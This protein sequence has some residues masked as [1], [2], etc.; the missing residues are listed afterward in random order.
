MP[1]NK[2]E[3]GTEEKGE[4]V[5]GRKERGL[6]GMPQSA[7]PAMST[8]SFSRALIRSMYV[9]FF[10]FPPA[11]PRR[12]LLL[13]ASSR[14]GWTGTTAEPGW[15]PSF[16]YCMPYVGAKTIYQLAKNPNCI[17]LLSGPRGDRAIDKVGCTIPCDLHSTVNHGGGQ[18]LVPED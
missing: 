18:T 5:E 8:Q 12:A 3:G 15:T 11:S 6:G 16:N 2:N 4:G 14:C 13:M 7:V 9:P 10:F 1:Q 17:P